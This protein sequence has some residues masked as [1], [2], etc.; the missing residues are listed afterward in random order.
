MSAMTTT[1]PAACGAPL[2]ASRKKSSAADH[3]TV[4]RSAR[5]ELEP[6]LDLD[7]GPVCER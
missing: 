1:M 5:P 7:L 2:K 3:P 6:S 4:W